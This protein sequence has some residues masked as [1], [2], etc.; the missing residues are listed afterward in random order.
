GLVSVAASA[1]SSLPLTTFAQNNGV[2]QMTGVA[3]R[4]V[5]KI[6]AVILVILGLFPGIGWFFT[7]IPA[8][9]LGGAMTLM[10]SMIAIAGIR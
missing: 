3:S 4:H 9:V 10:F 5:G 2:I 1:M 8:P 6:I 7:T